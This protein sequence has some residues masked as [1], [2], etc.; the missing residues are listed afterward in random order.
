MDAA[1]RR[2]EVLPP[3]I[4]L[5]ADAEPDAFYYQLRLA[6]PADAASGDGGAAGDGAFLVASCDAYQLPEGEALRQVRIVRELP[7]WA[8]DREAP[9]PPP[10]DWLLQ[11]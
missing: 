5:R 10:P 9:P 8:V 3:R 4:V 7:S 11:A 2:R 1:R 6:A